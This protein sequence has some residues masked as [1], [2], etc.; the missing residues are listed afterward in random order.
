MVSDTLS[1]LLGGGGIWYT[2]QGFI[3]QQKLKSVTVTDDLVDLGRDFMGILCFKN[4]KEI[5]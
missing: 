5:N 3:V 2:R 1:F 4:N